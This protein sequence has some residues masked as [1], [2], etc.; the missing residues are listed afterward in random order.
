MPATEETGGLPGAI[1]LD[2]HHAEE[3]AIEPRAAAQASQVAGSVRIVGHQQRLRRLAWRADAMVICGHDPEQWP[4]IT[5]APD[6]YA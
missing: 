6:F 3:A 2:A 4:T 5:R 1:H